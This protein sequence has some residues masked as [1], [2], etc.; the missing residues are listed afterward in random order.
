MKAKVVGDLDLEDETFI[1]S[2][3]FIGYFNE[4]LEEASGEVILMNQDYFLTKY[5]MP[6]VS[7]TR[8]Y[9]LPPNIYATKIRNIM[10]TSGAIIYEVRQYR[11]R[12]KFESVAYTEQYGTSDDYRYLL[13]NDV[14]GQAIL[15]FHPNM[16]DTA[17]LAPVAA[18]STPLTI[19][20]L[21]NSA[22]V[23]LIGEYCN[24]EICALTQVD[25][26]LDT[27]Q[28]YSGTTTLGLPTQGLPGA[29]PGSIAYITGDKVQLQA[30]PNGTVPGGLTAG[31]TYYVIA[32]ASGSIKLATTL[33]NALAGTAID[34]TTTGTVYFS[35]SVAATVAIQLATLMD[36]PEASKFCMQWVKC[37]CYEKEM[38]PRLEAAVG[39]LEGQRKQMTDTLVR[40]IDDDD[41]QIQMDFSIYNEMS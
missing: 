9:I 37:R 14:P 18:L 32:G 29:F 36:I 7:G 6:V 4:A 27:I 21:R 26:S 31:T 19:N 39:A 28:T 1:L 22:R 23:P 16:R 41:D 38:D 3:E 24:Q 12:Q 2:D 8:R 30:G 11:R 15:E 35:I 10:Y 40:G 17:V 13:W 34:L 33:A 25:T 20:Y 5:Y